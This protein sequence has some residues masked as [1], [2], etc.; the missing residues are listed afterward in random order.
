[1]AGEAE[2][3]KRLGQDVRDAR[4]GLGLSV[5]EAAK[6]AGVSRNTWQGL[7]DG[8]RATQDSKYESIQ[9]AL[10]WPAGEIVRRLAAYQED[11][12]LTDQ[13]IRRMTVDE[14]GTHTARIHKRDGRA[15]A[16]AFFRRASDLL[17]AAVE[18]PGRDH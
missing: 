18:L 9:G 17:S 8:T 11:R 13:E 14:I 4:V 10:Q 1:M 6:R 3:R 15:A 16:T 5:R 2:A 7:E 12:P